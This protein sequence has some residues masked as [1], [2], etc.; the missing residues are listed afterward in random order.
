MS[1]FQALILGIV[2]GLGEF[3]PISS[4][5]H[6]I[7]T[8][9]LLGFKDPGLGFNL[10]LHWGTF[11]AVIYYFRTDVRDLIRGFWHSLFKST[12]NFENNIY[13][14]LSWL[15]VLASVPGAL[16]GKLLQEQAEHAFRNPLLIAVT[17]SSFGIIILLADWFG[18]KTK[19]LDRITKLD[20]L[21][22]G[23]GQAL[24]I[25]PG[26]SRSG[27]TI[28]AG[29]IL[30]F[31]REDAARFSFLMSI[32]IIFGAGLVGLNSG[33]SGASLTNILVG[34]ISSA[35]VGFLSIK[36]M[37][38]YLAKHDYKIF[39]WYRLAFAALI[40]FVYFARK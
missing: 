34:F 15:L 24:A 13:Q 39:T 38:R 3:L 1:I 25:I 19:N 7:V 11:V 36:Y 17:M 29:L 18:E 20:A 37:L 10:A 2:Q 21:L 16:I 22:I 9:W 4:T 8:P 12:R 28:T 33:F 14:K 35:V 32:P 23:L 30:G 5:A 31:K 27:S 40:L 26:V 6:L